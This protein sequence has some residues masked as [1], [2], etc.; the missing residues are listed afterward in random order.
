M[1]DGVVDLPVSLKDITGE[2]WL[3]GS[4]VSC[5]FP[6]KDTDR[7]FAMVEGNELGFTSVQILGESQVLCVRGGLHT[8]YVIQK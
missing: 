7:I 6:E 5:N 1:A 8:E 2:F 3:E 4:Q